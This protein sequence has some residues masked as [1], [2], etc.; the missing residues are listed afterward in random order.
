[1]IQ[2]A[3]MLEQARLPGDPADWYWFEKH[4]IPVPRTAE[5]RS[6]GIV[7]IDLSVPVPADDLLEFSADVWQHVPPLMTV[8]AAVNVDCWCATNHRS[9]HTAEHMEWPASSH[10]ALADAFDKAVRTVVG[11]LHDSRDPSVWRARAGLP[12]PE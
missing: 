5:H 6:Y 8:T 7:G 9:P 11:W 2:S 3:E 10:E 1:M 4:S 12:N